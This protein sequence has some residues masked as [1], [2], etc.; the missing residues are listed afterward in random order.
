MA[1]SPARNPRGY[2]DFEHQPSAVTYD[3]PIHRDH[4]WRAPKQMPRRSRTPDKRSN[5]L[6]DIIF[7]TRIDLPDGRGELVVKSQTFTTP[8][9]D[10]HSYGCILDQHLEHPSRS[11][12]AAIIIVEGYAEGLGATIRAMIPRYLSYLMHWFG[13]AK[14]AIHLFLR[15]LGMDSVM[16][17][18]FSITVEG[19]ATPGVIL[20][21]RMQVAKRMLGHGLVL[22][23]N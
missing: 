7:I 22:F 9:N 16:L 1:S 5:V 23:S 6:V 14:S 17:R 20:T 10:D 8:I 13:I 12:E 3:S 2:P 11:D 19:M 18:S 21:V 15:S 4:Y